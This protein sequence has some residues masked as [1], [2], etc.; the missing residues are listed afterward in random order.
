MN[1]ENTLLECE[2]ILQNDSGLY[3]GWFTLS[4]SKYG[5]YVA[6]AVMNPSENSDEKYCRTMSK[7]HLGNSMKKVAKDLLKELQE[8][9]LAGKPFLEYGNRKDGKRMWGPEIPCESCKGTGAIWME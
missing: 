7:H 4:V 1:L 6:Y 2:K 9:E 3:H 8:W 5:T